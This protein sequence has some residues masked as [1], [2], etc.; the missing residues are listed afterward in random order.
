MASVKALSHAHA[1]FSMF[2]K[3]CQPG[4]LVLEPT[5]SGHCDLASPAVSR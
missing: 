3:S 2:L 4:T 1:K 5:E